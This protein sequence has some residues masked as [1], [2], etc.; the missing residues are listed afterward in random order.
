MDV[1]K[2][3]WE[4]DPSRPHSAA[5]LGEA[6]ESTWAI[7]ARTLATWTPESLGQEARRTSGD[8]VQLHTRQ[9]VLYRMLTH[10]AYHSGE[11]AL[12]L[13]THGLGGNTGPNGPI[14]LWAGLSRVE[15]R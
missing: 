15:R 6:L 11:I 8:V 2:G 9:S 12:T 10:D 7:V 5:E 4:D 1:S 3:G 13:G 14:D